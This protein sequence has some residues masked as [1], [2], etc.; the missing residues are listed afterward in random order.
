[1][2]VAGNIPH[3]T[4]TLSIAIYDAVQANNITMANTLVAIITVFSILVLYFV[5]RFTKGKY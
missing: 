3:K 5:N 2:M 1:L 4:Q